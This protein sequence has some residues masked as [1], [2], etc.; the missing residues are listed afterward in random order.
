MS[1][2]HAKLL[3]SKYYYSFGNYEKA[4]ELVESAKAMADE[5]YGE[6]KDHIDFFSILR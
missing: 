5:E 3:E 4:T 1:I 6:N 2:F